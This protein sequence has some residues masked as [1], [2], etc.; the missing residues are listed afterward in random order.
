MQ[1]AMPS[2]DVVQGNFSILSGA[3]LAIPALTYGIFV[4]WRWSKTQDVKSVV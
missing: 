3:M 2:H 1:T 4:C